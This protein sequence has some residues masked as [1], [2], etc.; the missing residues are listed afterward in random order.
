MAKMTDTYDA[1]SVAVQ[2]KWNG[3]ARLGMKGEKVKIRSAKQ[4]GRRGA[5]SVARLLLEWAPE[6]ED[7][8]IVVT[9]ASV[10]GEDLLL[11]PAAMRKYPFNP[12][13]KNTESIKIWEAYEQAV[14]HKEAYQVKNPG[15]WSVPIL[16]FKRNRSD[17]MVCLSADDFMRLIG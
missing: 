14:R 3:Q 9:P 12:E 5:E 15:K 17:L 6:L 10:P 7:K 2:A 16:F 1:S 8:D 4:K 11:S 13:V